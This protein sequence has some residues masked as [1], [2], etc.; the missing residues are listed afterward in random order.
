MSEC[1]SAPHTLCYSVGNTVTLC[2]SVGDT[3]T[4]CYSVPAYSVHTLDPPFTS[5]EAAQAVEG[6]QGSP[7]G[8]AVGSPAAVAGLGSPE[9]EQA[10]MPG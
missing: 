10:D 4:L 3:V 2:Y 5:T 6:S 1:Y 7:V 8:A 9:V